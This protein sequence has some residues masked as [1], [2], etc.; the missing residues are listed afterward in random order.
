MSVTMQT[1]SGRR[2]SAEAGRKSHEYGSTSG[3]EGEHAAARRSMAKD[4]GVLDENGARTTVRPA[5]GGG[6]SSREAE[7]WA[8]A[9]FVR[10][11]MTWG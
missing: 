7:A 4:A 10:G 3:P 2:P 11:L 8:R 5:C 6:K 1:G 9:S